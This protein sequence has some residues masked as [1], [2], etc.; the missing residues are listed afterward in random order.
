MSIKKAIVENKQ[1]TF[2]TEF[3]LSKLTDD[4]ASRICEAIIE[5]IIEDVTQCADE[6]WSEGDVKLAIGRVLCSRLGI[7]W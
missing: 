3:L 2:L 6:D 7:D 1:I 4:Y 5:D